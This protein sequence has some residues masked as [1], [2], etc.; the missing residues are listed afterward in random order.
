VE[1]F[2]FFV[3]RKN[4]KR[5]NLATNAYSYLYLAE[6]EFGKRRKSLSN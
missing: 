1:I 4:A 2:D 5:Q 3:S 6:K